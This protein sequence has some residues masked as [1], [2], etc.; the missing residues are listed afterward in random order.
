MYAK[1]TEKLVAKS[2]AAL[3]YQRDALSLSEIEE[4]QLTKNPTRAAEKLL[5]IVLS[6]PRN[7]VLECFLDA[8]KQ[9]RQGHVYMWIVYPG[10]KF[11][12]YN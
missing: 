2:A 10:K 8:L 12:F 5:N 6:R 4:I 7:F 3:M 9:T 11:L 1:L